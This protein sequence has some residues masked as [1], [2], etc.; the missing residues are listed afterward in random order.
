M[1]KSIK[2]QQIDAESSRLEEWLDTRAYE[3]ANA[4]HQRVAALKKQL[5]EA[6]HAKDFFEVYFKNQRLKEDGRRK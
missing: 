4:T 3:V 5:D 1:T 6:E 2:K